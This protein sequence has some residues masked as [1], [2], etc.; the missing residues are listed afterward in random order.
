MAR[1]GPQLPPELSSS[2]SPTSAAAGA[3]NAHV[4]AREY[5]RALRPGEGT[6][7]ASYVQEGKRIP[8]RG[9]IGLDSERIEAFENVGYVM[10]GSRHQRMNAVRMR[11]ENQIISAEEQRSILKMRAEEKAK[12]EQE[13]VEQFRDMVESMG[14][15]PGSGSQKR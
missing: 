1:I 15:G 14:D 9:E 3:S 6:A 5:G 8:R 10:S 13:I 12:K 2:A 11:K 4:D 7:M